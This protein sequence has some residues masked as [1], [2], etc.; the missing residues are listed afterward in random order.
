MILTC[1]ILHLV[2]A[3]DECGGSVDLNLIRDEN[4]LAPTRARVA[5]IGGVP[6]A[7]HEV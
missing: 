3:H 2:M 1:A 7:T 5:T 4:G 6:Q